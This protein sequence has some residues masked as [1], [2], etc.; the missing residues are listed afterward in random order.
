MDRLENTASN[1]S[2]VACVFVAA[3]T[4]FPSRC[5]ATL[6]GGPHRQQ[7]DLVCH[8]LFSSK[9]RKVGFSRKV[10]RSPGRPRRTW[11]DNIK[12]DQ[13]EIGWG[14]IHW[15]DLVQDRVQWRALL[16][17][18]MNFGFHKMLGS[19]WV[20]AQLAV[21]QEESTSVSSTRHSRVFSSL[22]GTARM[23]RMCYNYTVIVPWRISAV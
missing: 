12:M 4:C 6:G 15:I 14:G 3:V 21:S 8:L 10:R 9:T 17:T 23:L 2:I 20:D 11:V 19:S 1:C 16:N 13:R 22:E 7:G 18:V 5:L